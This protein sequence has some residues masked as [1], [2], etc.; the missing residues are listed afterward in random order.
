VRVVLGK[1][2]TDVLWPLGQRWFRWGFHLP[3]Y[4]DPEVE[5]LAAYRE[6][7]GDPSD[8]Y[9]DRTVDSEGDVDILPDSRL[10]ELIAERAPWFAGI[11]EDI[12]W[13]T[14]VRFERRLTTS[15][16]RGACWL[17]GDSAHLGNPIGVHSLNVGIAEAID[18]GSML[19]ASVKG[20]T[21][22]D[23][24]D[25]RWQNEW[26]RLLA[27]PEATPGADPWVR[28]N[29]HRIVPCLPGYGDA[30][31]SMAAQLGLRV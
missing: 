5:R 23:G 18:L 30:L 19:S 16:G 6:R 22:P 13:R 4:T 8:R 31:A 9:K 28:D 3:E 2:T 12:G 14:V 17:A 15:F 7:Y 29:R 10:R 27:E 20:E 25:R 11:V 24:Y 21:V 26:R 1:D